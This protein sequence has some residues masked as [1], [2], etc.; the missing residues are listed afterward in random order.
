MDGQTDGHRETEDLVEWLTGC[1]PAG[2]T[3]EGPG[4]QNLFSSQGWMSD[5]V[6]SRHKNPKVAPMSWSKLT[7]PLS[8]PSS[9]CRNSSREPFFPNVKVIRPTCFYIIGPFG[10]T[11]SKSPNQAEPCDFQQRETL[12]ET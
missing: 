4:I 2:P 7:K 8:S 1:S 10:K 6:F 9:E 11:S 3:M 12:K 5:L